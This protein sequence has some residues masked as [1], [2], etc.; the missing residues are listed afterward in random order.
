LALMVLGALALR[1]RADWLML[2]WFTSMWLPLTLVSGL[3]DPGFIRI[4]ASLMRYWVPV[5]PAMCLGATAAVAGA[6][7]VVRRHALAARPGVATALTATLAALG[8]LGWC[9]PMLDDIADNPRDRAWSAMRSALA[10]NDAPIDTLITDDRD[11]LVLGI[12]S[13]EP[14]GGD[15]VV[16]ARVQRTGH[17]LPRPPRSDGDPGTWLIWTSG[18]SR[19]TPK[20][21]QGWE[22]VLRERGLRLYAPRAL[23]A[24]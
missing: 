11:A 20:P 24:G 10:D 13:R 1:R 22:L 6:L 12:Y 9:V 3:I 18:L 14:V 5:L 4:N 8:L 23:A 16:H 21:G 2:A 7:S 19:R 17:A 15:L